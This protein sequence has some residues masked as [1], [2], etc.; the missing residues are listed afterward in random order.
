MEIDTKNHR[1]IALAM[2]CFWTG[3]MGLGAIDGVVKT[4]AG[5]LDGREVTLVTYH[6]EVIQ[7]PEL[8]KK[9]AQIDCAHKV[10]LKTEGERAVAEKAGRFSL[11]RLDSSYR[12]AKASDQK[13]QLQ[14]TRYALI[15]GLSPIQETKVNA[16]VRSNQKLAY[17]YLTR[18]Q[19][20][21]LKK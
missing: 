1:E 2:H 13:R 14:G 20:Q 8:I 17:Q 10:Y 15:K 7:L 3:E 6:N 11:G 5:W 21:S 18:R 12:P 19:Q 4:E 16:F 9:A